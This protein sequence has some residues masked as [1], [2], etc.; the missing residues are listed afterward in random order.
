MTPVRFRSCHTPLNMVARLDDWLKVIA[1][2]DDIVAEPHYLE[3]AGVAAMKKAYGIYKKKGYRLR[4]L[5]A[6]T[7]NHMH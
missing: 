4:L 1:N 5:S 7:C 3:W 2:R 6:A